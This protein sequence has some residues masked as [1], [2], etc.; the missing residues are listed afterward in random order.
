MKF[1]KLFLKTPKYNKGRCQKHLE[2]GLKKFFGGTRNFHQDL[3]GG[4]KTF[5]NMSQMGGQG[6][7]PNFFAVIL[8][9]LPSKHLN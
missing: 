2:G 5:K 1:T 3:G 8:T 4:Q 7:N 6:S 9:F